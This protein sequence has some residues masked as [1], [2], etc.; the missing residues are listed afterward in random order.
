MALLKYKDDVIKVETGTSV[1]EALLD[2]GQEI[3]NSCRAG[4]CQSCVMQLTKGSVPEQAQRGLK[5]AHK[6]KGLFLACSCHPEEDIEVC[7]PDNNQL[8]VPATVHKLIKRPGDVVELQLKTDS[9]FDYRAGQFVTLW[10]NQHLARSYSLT[11]M[12]QL[13]N[14]LTFHIKRIP[15]GEFS[16]WIHDELQLGETLSVQG[17]A[18]DCFYIPGAAEQDLLLVGTGTGLAPLLGI[19]QDA[20]EN[21]HTGAIHLIHGALHFP[22]LYYHQE[23]TKLA[24]ANPNVHYH[25]CVLNK[26][27]DLPDGVK[28]ASVN[29]VVTQVVEK[30]VGWKAYLCGD[31]DL[32]SKLRKQIFLAGCDMKNIYADPFLPSQNK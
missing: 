26:S 4:A 31:P 22:G 10:R 30:P 28:T 14:L 27:D 12:P 16:S 21:G 23:L 5:D 25:P 9:S 1:L 2:H 20:L 11:T 7:L 8:R 24:A 3:P 32:V 17:P 6:L 29:D 15:G 13:D 19:I 18:G